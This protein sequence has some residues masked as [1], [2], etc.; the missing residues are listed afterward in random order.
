[1]ATTG[2]PSV[3]NPCQYPFQAG[4]LRGPARRFAASREWKTPYRSNALRFRRF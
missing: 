4:P 3:V 1:M 2:E